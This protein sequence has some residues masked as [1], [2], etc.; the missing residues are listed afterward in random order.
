[1]NAFHGI[2]DPAVGGQWVKRKKWP[3]ELELV[4]SG[5]RPEIRPTAKMIFP[6]PKSS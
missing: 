6:L 3:W 5:K 4:Y 1:M 2:I